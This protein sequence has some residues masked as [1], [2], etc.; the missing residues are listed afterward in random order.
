MFMGEVLAMTAFGLIKL[1]RWQKARKTSDP[2]DFPDA[3]K[4]DEKANLSANL[5]L[6]NEG[7]PATRPKF[8]PFWLLPPAILDLVTFY[9]ITAI[10]KTVF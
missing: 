5:E 1:Y 6:A 10:F 8:S 2:T 3:P 9:Y 7:K 4:P